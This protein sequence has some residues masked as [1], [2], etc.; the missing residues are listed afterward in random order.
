MGVVIHGPILPCWNTGSK[1][2][3][4]RGSN[5]YTSR[6]RLLLEPYSAGIMLMTMMWRDG[7][8]TWGR[9]LA[10]Q[11]IWAALS[12]QFFPSCCILCG[13]AC[14]S[15]RLCPACLPALPRPEQPCRRCA[16]P[17][18]HSA[19]RLCAACIS[20]PPSW[21]RA[22]A[23][24]VYDY[25]VNHFVQQFKFSRDLACGQLLA[26]ELSRAVMQSTAPRPDLLLPV[27][28]HAARKFQR[29]F[30][31]AEFLAREVAA[32]TGIRVRA[33]CL[34]R[35]KHTKAQSGL[36]RHARRQNVRGAFTSGSLAGL[37]I[38]LVDDVLT[39]GTTLD[40]CARIARKA[41]AV[42]VSVWVAAR[43]TVSGPA[44]SGC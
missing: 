39:T 5:S 31:Q 23:A 25:P 40:A 14:G 29:G 41:G 1:P 18:M 19:S 32:R 44:F 27:P 42:H 34:R 4:R 3:A 21:D 24:L 7:S 37:G 6:R 28:L 2:P 8:L 15:H 13:D 16:L 10:A 33:G 30:N 12:Q 26:D 20:H 9:S 43:V 22:I 38:A 17:A 35:R 11:S 36:D